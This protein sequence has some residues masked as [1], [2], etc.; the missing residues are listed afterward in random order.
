MYKLSCAS[1]QLQSP[2]PCEFTVQVLPCLAV[3][4]SKGCITWLRMSL[5]VH[6]SR[7]T[8]KSCTR[9]PSL[10]SASKDCAECRRILRHIRRVC[11]ACLKPLAVTPSYLDPGPP[12]SQG[13]ALSCALQQRLRKWRIA[14]ASAC[15]WELCQELCRALV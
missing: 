1:L 4:A 11:F 2:R 3:H 6:G 15:R 12:P 10:T 8:V 13:A 5:Q 9:P 14:R 7:W